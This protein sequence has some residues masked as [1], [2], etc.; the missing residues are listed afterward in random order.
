ML[1][2]QAE[3][4]PSLRSSWTVEIAALGDGPIPLIEMFCLDNPD[5]DRTGL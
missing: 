3:S 1:R 4:S 2:I 5:E